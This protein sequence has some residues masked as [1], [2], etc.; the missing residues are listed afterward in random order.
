[1]N[2][3]FDHEVDKSQFSPLMRLVSCMFWL[4]PETR[5]ITIHILTSAARLLMI[6]SRLQHRGQLGWERRLVLSDLDRIPG[7]MWHRAI[8]DCCNTK[9]VCGEINCLKTAIHH[10]TW[11]LH[12]IKNLILS[13]DWVRVQWSV[14][15]PATCTSPLELVA[16]FSQ[17]RNH[18]KH[19][20]LDLP[21][22]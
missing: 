14:L 2:V 4:W 7:T 6:T 16:K 9:L 22:S 13:P 10:N 5:L 8:V 19:S 15:P 18:R 12:S 17:S 21:V 1:M 3:C 20:V 11:H